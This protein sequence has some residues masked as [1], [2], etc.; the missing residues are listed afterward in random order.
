MRLYQYSRVLAQLVFA[1]IWLGGS[2]FYM[3][4][5]NIKGG[6]LPANGFTCVNSIIQL[7]LQIEGLD[8]TGMPSTLTTC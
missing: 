7:G 2:V 6:L 1:R 5:M 8:S 3:M 4:T